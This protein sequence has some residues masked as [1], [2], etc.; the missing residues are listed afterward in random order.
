MRALY[1]VYDPTSP[2]PNRT[3]A[4]H[5]LL[6]LD[7]I[8]TDT[9][10]PITPADH[11]GNRYLKLLPDTPTCLKRRK[12]LPNKHA[13]T[14]CIQHQIEKLQNDVG[15][16]IKRYHS[17]N[18]R[19]IQRASLH[20]LQPQSAAFTLM[21]PHFSAQNG[22]VERRLLPVFDLRPPWSAAN[23]PRIIDCTR[24]ERNDQSQLLPLATHNRRLHFA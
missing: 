16:T 14:K 20:A 13:A 23:F 12:S 6:S 17:D 5:P 15:T 4:Q 9:T 11:R 7:A 2:L 22:L 8:S 18:A 1:P 10:E 24:A 21:A 19:E 3:R